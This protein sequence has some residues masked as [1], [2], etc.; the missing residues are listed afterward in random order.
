MGEDVG[1][2]SETVAELAGG[3]IGISEV[4]PIGALL[5]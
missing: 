3:V 1:G 5:S 2:V 4:L